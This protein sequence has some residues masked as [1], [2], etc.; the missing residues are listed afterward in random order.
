MSTPLKNIVYGYLDPRDGSLR[1]VGKSA[2]G[3]RRPN[4]LA[5]HRHGYCGNWIKNLATNGLQPIVVV[6]D[7]LGDD[8]VD[9]DLNEAEKRQ[10]ALARVAGAKLTNLTNG[11][12]GGIVCDDFV[13]RV[14]K[15]RGPWTDEQRRKS[16][17][18]NKARL[19][20][21]SSEE[22]SAIS[23]KGR[24]S[25]VATMTARNYRHSSKTLEKIADG[26]R[27]YQARVR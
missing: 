11:G 24:A 16:S 12:D 18:T 15:A 25:A 9:A 10:I 1:Y 27:R 14:Q 2:V 21:L 23:R 22:K 5:C 19:S 26:Q 3:M 4:N 13:R 17:A 6:L 20:L 7:A 8:A